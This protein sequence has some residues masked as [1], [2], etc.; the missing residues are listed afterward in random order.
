MRV[1]V[2]VRV[3]RVCEVRDCVCGRKACAGGGKRSHSI[4]DYH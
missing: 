2:R 1:C 4:P 3:R